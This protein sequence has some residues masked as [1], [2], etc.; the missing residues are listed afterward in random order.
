MVNE[1]NE[2]IVNEVNEVSEVGEVSTTWEICYSSSDDPYGSQ[3]VLDSLIFQTDLIGNFNAWN[4]AASMLMLI[5]AGR[6]TPAEAAE[7]A[8]SIPAVP[9]RMETVC[10]APWCIVDYAHTAQGMTKAVAAS[11]AIAPSHRLMVVFGC[12]GNRDKAKRGPMLQ[13]ALQADRVVL[14]SDNPRNE[15]PEHIISDSLQIIT[16]Q[17]VAF[18]VDP[19]ASVQV[20]PDRAAAITAGFK[21]ALTHQQQGG[22]ALLL[23][24]GKGHETGQIVGDTTYPWHDATYLR[25]L[26]ESVSRYGLRRNG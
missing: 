3:P 1:V 11:Q 21:Q 10:D 25:S 18:G 17:R 22:L 26:S 14:T 13:A 24:C 20:I 2:V 12:G 8:R 7:R 5:A 16:D 9:G 6:L 4:I 15:D 19:E 23:V